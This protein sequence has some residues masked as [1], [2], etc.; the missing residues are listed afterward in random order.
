MKNRILIRG[1]V[2]LV[3]V[4]TCSALPPLASAGDDPHALAVG[5]FALRMD[6]QID[7]AVKML[8]A[9]LADSPEAGVLHYELARTKLLLLDIPATREEALAAVRCAPDDNR[10]RYFAAMVS[11]YAVIDAAHHNDQ[12]R[13]KEMGREALDQLGSILAADQDHHEARWLLVQ[14]STEMGPQL[15]L[16]VEDPET[17]VALLEKMDPVLGAKAR[18]CLVDKD[19]QRE[20]WKQILSDHPDDCRA[21]A[22]AAEGLIQVGELDLAE[23]CLT[24]A[25]GKD[26][27]N[28]YG[29]LGL[30]LAYFMQQDWERARELT[31]RYLDTEPPLALEAYAIGRLGM[32]YRRSGNEER[33]GELMKQARELDPH[34]WQTVMPPPEEIFMPI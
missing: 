23:E 5:A 12:K 22:E 9:G 29:L 1:L 11:A 8:E 17:H 15:G 6:G 28:C 33:A 16:E 27:R 34:V 13:M 31:Q 19:K 32:I 14:L 24:K 20:L 7:E 25:I 4:L 26:K 18:C 30:G 10:F 21:L 2:G 3:I